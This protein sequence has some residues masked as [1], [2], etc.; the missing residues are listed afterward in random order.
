MNA[1]LQQML[2]A[3]NWLKQPGIIVREKVDIP[4]AARRKIIAKKGACCRACHATS[5][6]TVDHRIARA[7]GGT[8]DI[9]NLQVLCLGCNRA[10]NRHELELLHLLRSDEGR[11][12]LLRRWQVLMQLNALKT[13]IKNQRRATQRELAYKVV[14][15]KV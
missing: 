12:E 9:S 6:L 4:A 8:N 5:D 11:V 14:H 10:K 1:L 3:Q 15:G 7:L 13:R 2:E